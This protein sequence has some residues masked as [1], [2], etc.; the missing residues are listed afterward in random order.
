[1]SGAV[2]DGRC[3]TPAPQR[4]PE[5]G[6]APA[7]HLQEV[8]VVG[9][10]Q[11]VQYRAEV[12]IVIQRIAVGVTRRDARRTAGPAIGDPVTE[13]G[14]RRGRKKRRGHLAGEPRGEIFWSAD[15]A[16]P[17]AVLQRHPRPAIDRRE[18]QFDFREFSWIP[19]RLTPPEQN[20]GAGLP[21]HDAADL[22][23]TLHDATIRLRPEIVP[24]PGER[25]GEFLD[26]NVEGRRWL[27]GHVDMSVDGGSRVL[28]P[29]DSL[30]DGSAWT[31][32]LLTR[33][34]T[35]SAMMCSASR[36]S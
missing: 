8:V 33:G 1:M 17:P 32:V 23:T 5:E 21:G 31:Q 16:A 30:G 14:G 7:A 11:F 29:P 34:I 28:H 2:I 22:D 6:A 3:A 9:Q 35:C 25:G 27:K 13:G 18:P 26:E 24:P 10:R 36:S 19:V 15:Q 20:T 4:P 12:G